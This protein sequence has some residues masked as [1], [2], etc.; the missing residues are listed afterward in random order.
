[1]YERRENWQY[2]ELFN[3]LEAVTSWNPLS[4]SFGGEIV[5]PSLGTSLRSTV[6]K[7]SG[8][9]SSSSGFGFITLGRVIVVFKNY[10]YF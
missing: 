5:W 4:S 9:V 2:H 8:V 7:D 6:S 10:G 1:M 3:L